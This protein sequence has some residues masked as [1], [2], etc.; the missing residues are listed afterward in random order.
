LED[1]RRLPHF[2]IRKISP[3]A[4]DLLDAQCQSDGANKPV[5][6]CDELAEARDLIRERIDE[7]YLAETTVPGNVDLWYG[8]EIR[9]SAVPLVLFVLQDADLLPHLEGIVRANSKLWWEGRPFSATCID[10]PVEA[11]ERFGMSRESWNLR[12]FLRQQFI[13]HLVSSPED[14]KIPVAA[15]LIDE[16]PADLRALNELPCLLPL[17]VR[18]NP[19]KPHQLSRFIAKLHA[20]SPGFAARSLHVTPSEVGRILENLADETDDFAGALRLPELK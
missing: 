18:E 7:N 20:G 3:A 4:I 13:Y 19:L 16:D 12:D 11:L 1:L 14:G 5:P 2:F 6:E 9:S 8:P 15:I 10:M 17:V